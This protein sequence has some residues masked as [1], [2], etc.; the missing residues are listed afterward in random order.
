MRVAYFEC[1]AGISGDMVLGALLDAGLEL[2]VLRRELDKLGLDEFELEVSREQRHGL[3][4]TRAKVTA[5]EGHVH[6][7]LSD[8]LAIING[9]RLADTIKGRAGDVF[10]RLAEAE[11]EVHGTT[12]EQVHFHEVGAVDAIVDIVGAVAGLNCLGIERV[13]GSRLRFGTGSTV[14]A[15]GAMP[16]PVPAVVALC[17]GVPTERT[18]IPFEMVTPTGAA[19][20]TTLAHEIGERI[21]LRTEHVGYGV[22]GRDPDRVPNLLRLEIGELETP[23]RSDRI[24]LIE[25][26]VDDMNPE[27]YPY[28]MERLFS[29]GA[30]DAY[31]TPVIMK[32]GRPGVLVTVMAEPEQVQSLS[33]LLLRE[34]STLGV[35]IS[36]AD[37]VVLEREAGTVQTPFGPIQVKLAR[38]DDHARVTPEYED[39]ARVA[40]DRN[41]PIMDVYRAAQEAALED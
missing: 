24:T 3:S 29:E 26:N 27:V 18:D 12:P 21:T 22:G 33:R 20:L 32:K 31:L 40:R 23:A 10:R 16:I 36:P 19:L 1:T 41:V 25:T 38:L 11:A 6:R 34:T 30:R 14:G 2:E 8:V 39:C 5:R 17:K 15:H 35:R 7:G 28:L 37:R 4:G 13:Y 9:S